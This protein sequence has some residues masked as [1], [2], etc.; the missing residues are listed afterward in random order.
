MPFFLLC[1]QSNNNKKGFEYSFHQYLK[2]A[3]LQHLVWLPPEQF[4]NTTPFVI[5]GKTEP[6]PMKVGGMK[7]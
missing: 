7:L 4:S 6:R 3:P 1:C 5:F 2:T